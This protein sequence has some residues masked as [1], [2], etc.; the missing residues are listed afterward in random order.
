LQYIYPHTPYLPKG[1]PPALYR[2]I[3]PFT[4]SFAYRSSPSFAPA[5]NAND[6]SGNA[7]QY[8]ISHRFSAKLPPYI[9]AFLFAVAD[10]KHAILPR[11]KQWRTGTMQFYLAAYCDEPETRDSTS[12]YI[13]ADKNHAILSRRILRRTLLLRQKAV[14]IC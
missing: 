13:A 14:G 2:I 5:F 8:I 9:A 7:T 3:A 1:S 11:R 12:P 4:D 10:R 6:T